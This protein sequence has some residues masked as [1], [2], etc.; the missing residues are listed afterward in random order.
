[1]MIRKLALQFLMF[2]FCAWFLGCT[3][4]PGTEIAKGPSTRGE[5]IAEPLPRIVDNAPGENH[6]DT[7][8]QL[9]DGGINRQPSFQ[10]N[11]RKVG[12]SSVR[13]P[14]DG[15]QS[16]SMFVD[17]TGLEVV[18]EE[19]PKPRVMII[20]AP[21]GKEIRCFTALAGTSGGDVFAGAFPPSPGDATEVL[22]S[23][24]G[25][26]PQ[27]I[28]AQNQIAGAPT[29]SPDGRYVVYSGESG[30][31]EYDLFAHDLEAGISEK[32]T[33]T[34]GFDGDPYFSED[35]RRLLF[36][37]QRNDSDPEEYNLFVA[38]WLLIQE[39]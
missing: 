1:M 18:S 20:S 3:G 37:S 21:S 33:T 34:A 12:F 9:T 26:E 39:E 27:V 15:S 25:G 24:D 4:N 32:I 38:N 8:I 28:S 22:V 6:F 29:L 13:P 35:G 19:P 36:V 31:G 11:G 16:Y 7:L 5:N 23:I 30:E 17:A 2:S 14:H 10:D